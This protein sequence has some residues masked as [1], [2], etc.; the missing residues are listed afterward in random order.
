MSTPPHLPHG[1]LPHPEGGRFRELHRSPHSVSLAD[2]RV[3][4]ALTHIYFHLAGNELSRFHLV[5]QEEV[6]NLYQGG[7]RLYLYDRS[8]G[9]RE[10]LLSPQT[11]CYCAVIPA[12]VWQAAE[13]VGGP[14]LAGC[15]VAP[16][17]DFADFRL[18][19][20]QDPESATLRGLGL[21]RFL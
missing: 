6:W 12:G 13:S 2:G 14:A 3:R 7:L 4:T 20:G 10:M 19:S 5:R 16:G 1:L 21:E 17:F 18:I 9:L 11:A 15:T 8:E